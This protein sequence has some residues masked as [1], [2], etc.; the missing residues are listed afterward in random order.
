MNRLKVLSIEHTTETFDYKRYD[1]I[2]LILPN[3]ETFKI[4]LQ[5]ILNFQN[6]IF[7]E[8]R[9]HFWN[10]HI[11]IQRFEKYT[12]YNIRV[13]DTYTLKNIYT[14]EPFIQEILNTFPFEYMKSLK[15]K[16][17]ETEDERLIKKTKQLSI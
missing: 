10:P 3:L 11:Y 9:N 5:S 15:R 16:I 12:I 4:T 13:F 7:Y 6:K 14:L 17:N 2:K 1:L 8:L